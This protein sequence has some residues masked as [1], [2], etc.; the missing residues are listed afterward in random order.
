LPVTAQQPKL[1]CKDP[2]PQME[3]TLCA[4][5]D[6]ERADKALN[7][8]YAL[9]RKEAKKRD[10][11]GGEGYNESEK[12]LI[13]AQRAWVAYRDAHCEAYSYQV[14]GGSMQP[15]VM[16]DCEADLT[17]KRTEELKKM[18]DIN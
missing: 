14:N 1:N 10:V 8:Q 12:T 4:Q 3:F 5:Q 11:E 18:Y 16:A 6:Y 2:G 9:T 15:Q 17:R 7:A 13:A